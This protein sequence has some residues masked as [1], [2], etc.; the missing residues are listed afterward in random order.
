MSTTGQLEYSYIRLTFIII[1]YGK[2]K[3][4]I[5]KSYIKYPHPTEPES[6]VQKNIISIHDRKYEHYKQWEL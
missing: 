5:D 3:R 2:S 6:C 4:F 1:S